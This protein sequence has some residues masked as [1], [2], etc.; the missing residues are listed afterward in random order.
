MV[1]RMKPKNGTA[2]F[3]KPSDFIY[4]STNE[5]FL[6]IDVHEAADIANR[7]LAERGVRV[8][9]FHDPL[10]PGFTEWRDEAPNNKQTHQG[11]LVCVEP[12]PKRECEHE[13]IEEVLGLVDGF[14]YVPE[15]K[16]CGVALKAKWEAV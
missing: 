2:S 11:L 13:A 1:V 7:L 6:D 3:F 14:V 15:C 10:A 9:A 12:L 8:R 4:K 5:D 16:H